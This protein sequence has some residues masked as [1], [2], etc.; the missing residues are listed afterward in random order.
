MA[1]AFSCR[2]LFTRSRAGKPHLAVFRCMSVDARQ[3]TDLRRGSRARGNCGL[4][5]GDLLDLRA[6]CRSPRVCATVVI[7][8]CLTKLM[9]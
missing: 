6:R 5:N 7:R 4:P 2:A 3:A 8:S 9:C 1:C